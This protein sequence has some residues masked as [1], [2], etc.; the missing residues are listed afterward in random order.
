[1]AEFERSTAKICTIQEL[2]TGKFIKNEGWEPSYIVTEFG[3]I[4][5]ANIIGVIVS[6]ENNTCIL[7]DG[8]GKVILRSFSGNINTEI[9]DLVNVIG[10]P[11][12]FNDDLFLNIEII[13]KIKNKKWVDFRKKELSLRQKKEVEIE[14]DYISLKEDK[15]E[16]KNQ[17]KLIKQ[18]TENLGKAEIIIKIIDKL[19]NGPGADIEEVKKECNFDDVD[20]IIKSLMEEGD[21]FQI[22]PGRLKVM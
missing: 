19:D 12:Q 9:G 1:M 11:R 18:E 22:K 2:N 13:K 16:T 21:V 3:K 6:K 7:D 15:P 4:M 17:E 20:K 10:K 8:S 5:R 14:E